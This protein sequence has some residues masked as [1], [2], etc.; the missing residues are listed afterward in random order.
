M[1]A[2]D[3]RLAKRSLHPIH[4]VLLSG[5]IPLFL[6]GL[7]SDLAYSSNY[8]IQWSNFASR[9]ILGGLLFG[10]C[11]LLWAMINLLRVDY[12]GRLT[13]LYAG[14]LLATCL[15]G[16]FNA[17]IHAKDAWATMPMGLNLSII[18]VL[19]ACASAWVG[20]SKLGVGGAR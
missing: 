15:A 10:G 1:P 11:A 6:G 14:I 5:T 17:L 18:A 3:D 9:L 8:H 20:F 19:L 7:L 13:F 12:R 4:G 2:I 16:F